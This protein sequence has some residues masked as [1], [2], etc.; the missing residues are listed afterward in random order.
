MTPIFQPLNP[1]MRRVIDGWIKVEAT[2]AVVIDRVSDNDIAFF[3]VELSGRYG[4]H[5]KAK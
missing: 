5:P 2:Y 1:C 4:E 3:V